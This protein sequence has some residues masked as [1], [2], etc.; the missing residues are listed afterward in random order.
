MTKKVILALG[1]L[2][3]L[4]TFTMPAMADTILFSFGSSGSVTATPSGGVVTIFL[5]LQ[6]VQDDA[7]VPISIS[8]HGGVTTGADSTWTPSVTMLQ[9]GFNAGPSNDVFVNDGGP[10]IYLSGNFGD[11]LP[12]G[13]FK[14]AGTKTGH[15]SGS[16][17]PSSYDVSQINTWFPITTGYVIVP[18]SG[19]WTLQTSHDAYNTTTKTFSATVTGAQI[20]FQLVPIPEPGTLALVG[21]GLLGLAGF[22]RRKSA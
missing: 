8:G 15:I 17:S 7:A 1:C 21:S 18:D 19:I 3:L 16:F 10:T 2:V 12:G 11:A 20:S 9:A 22:I 14:L 4:A 13:S 6:N 5:K